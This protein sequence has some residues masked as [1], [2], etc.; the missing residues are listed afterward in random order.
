MSETGDLASVWQTSRIIAALA[1][2]LGLQACN[3][4]EGGSDV[5]AVTTPASVALTVADVGQILAQAIAEASARGRPATL[6]VVDRVGN[7]L[8]VFVMDGAPLD[9]SITSG[10]GVT[11]GLDGLMLTG[12]AVA[13]AIAKAVT[14]AYLSSGGNAFT[15]RTANQIIQEHFNPGELG[16]PGG[17]LFGVQFSQL[18]CS[19]LNVRFI[20]GLP[21]ET[22]GPK[23]SPLGFSADP[24]GLPLYKDGSV[25]GG[26]GAISDGIYGLDLDIS[27]FDTDDDELIAV[28]GTV[29]FAAPTGI[30][31][32]HITVEGKSL[33]YADRGV[34][35]LVSD[36]ANAPAF[37]DGVDGD[38]TAVI[39]YFDGTIIAGQIFGEAASG[40]RPDQ[41][42]AFGTL[43]A[44]ILVDGMDDPRFP[45]IAG[46][47]PAGIAL[48]QAEVT[49]ILINALDVAFQARA[50]IRRPLNSHAQVTVTVVDTNGRVL[51]L[52]RTPDAPMFGTDVALQKART[53]AFFSSND[54]ADQLIAADGATPGTFT[55]YVDAAQAFIGPT[56]LTDG[57]AF[58]DRAGGNLSR[59]FYPDG[60]N[61]TA[62]GPF[63]LPFDQWSPFSTGLQLDLVVDDII[64]H[65]LFVLGIKPTDIDVGCT[66]LPLVMATGTNRI[67]NGIQ[68][69]PGS[70]PIYRDAALVGG[71]GVS[72]DGIDQDDL[73]AFL[74]L[75]DAGVELATGIGNAPQAIRADNLVPAGTRLRYVNCPFSPFLDS[76]DQNVCDG[77]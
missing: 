42:G 67:P 19:D 43:D 30:R 58:S 3:H 65:V 33:R 29:G 66:S 69:F 46:T 75:H 38:L 8:A 76:N 54:A 73:I 72:G 25:V 37:V 36:P 1:C 23:R 55:G 47:A 64:Q 44:Y 16:Q 59:P 60:I 48:T 56:A 52:V 7:V 34:E 35:S 10:R 26:I 13:A 51:G 20:S 77:K 2:L 53:A 57:T 12:A 9:V 21:Q 74:G 18:P 71:I 31:A 49:T 70:V 63:S 40:I 6:A 22:I 45:P 61:G 41:S 50:Q 17:P 15:T 39:G 68:I 14:G 27:D 28:A 24:G 4:G 5:V 62:N 32:N 11:T